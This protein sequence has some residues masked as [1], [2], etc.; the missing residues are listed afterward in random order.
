[1]KPKLVLTGD[2]FKTPR[3]LNGGYQAWAN[4]LYGW[5]KGR[6]ILVIGDDVYVYR[7]QYQT[8]ASE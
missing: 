2:K 5:T 3:L 8:E 4:R 6:V 7:V 1:M